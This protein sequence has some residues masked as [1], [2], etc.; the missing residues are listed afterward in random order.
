MSRNPFA[1]RHAAPKPSLIR[2]IIDKAA[3]PVIFLTVVSG[4]VVTVAGFTA[5]PTPAAAQITTGTA[6]QLPAPGL[7]QQIAA[8]ISTGGTIPPGIAAPV[9][10]ASTMAHITRTACTGKTTR[11]H[12]VYASGEV[13]DTT[14]ATTTCGP[15]VRKHEIINATYASGET[16]AEQLWSAT[17]NGQLTFEYQPRYAA[18]ASGEHVW[19]YTTVQGCAK[20]VQRH[21]IYASGEV[22]DTVTNSAAC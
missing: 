9:T 20:T 21:A 1:G 7:T 15:T 8:S 5:Q 10:A 14:T 2:R 22:R 13:R 12:A 6:T 11:S 16:V 17:V 19:T 18:Y 3:G 4:A